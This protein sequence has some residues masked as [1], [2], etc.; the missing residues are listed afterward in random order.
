[1]PASSSVKSSGF[2]LTPE[3]LNVVVVL[4]ILT[5]HNRTM[6]AR[7]ASLATHTSTLIYLAIMAFGLT[8][9]LIT[10]LSYF[11]V[12][13]FQKIALAALLILSALTAFYTDSLGAI[14]DEE[15]VNNVLTTHPSEGATLITTPM[16]LHVLLLGV[17][18]A[19]LV[20]LCPLKRRGWIK[21]TLVWALTI[22]VGL[23]C[24]AGAKAL[25]YK[26]FVQVSRGE[27]NSVTYTL[28][29]GAFLVATT[30]LL[31]NRWKVW[32]M[33]FT[34]IGLDAQRGVKIS[35]A[36]KPV[37]LF[38]VVGETARAQNQQIDGY[39]RETN[40][41]LS[42]LDILNFGPASSCATS[43]KPSLRCMFSKFGRD[44]MSYVKFA[45]HENLLDIA[46]HA[47]IGVEWY[48]ND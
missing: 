4:F 45:T 10:L 2:A 9:A 3:L 30:S 37:V 33:P 25:G 43:T 7:A 23:G 29:P 22:G 46:D 19:I 26:A 24:F 34:Q 27:M 15:L 35:H 44:Q 11:A 12:R 20:L 41:L 16:I 28:Q 8:L 6:F 5:A 14:F 40:P 21:N 1:M 18:P 39:A 17:L 13:W 32:G 36:P 42:T 48:D 47:K 38:L 31:K